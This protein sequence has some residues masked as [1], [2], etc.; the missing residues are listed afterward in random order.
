MAESLRWGSAPRRRA[1]MPMMPAQQPAS[2]FLLANVL[3][4]LAPAPA[5]TLRKASLATAYFGAAPDAVDATSGGA[6]VRVKLAADTCHWSPSRCSVCTDTPGMGE[7]G[8]PGG[9]TV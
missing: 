7:P 3:A 5:G 6:W 2:G 9:R 1:S 8:A 4:H